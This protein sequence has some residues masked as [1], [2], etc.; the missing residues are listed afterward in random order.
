[1]KYPYNRISHGDYT[2]WARPTC[3][4]N[5]GCQWYIVKQHKQVIKYDLNYTNMYFNSHRNKFNVYVCL[6]INANKNPKSLVRQWDT[7]KT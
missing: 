6:C 2:A 1:M 5:K 3:T 7:N 4:D